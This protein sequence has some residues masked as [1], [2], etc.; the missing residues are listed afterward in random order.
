MH[1][2]QIIG[3]LGFVGVIVG[4]LFAASWI[5]D[6]PSDKGPL[7]R[8]LIFLA[9]IP[10][11]VVSLVP[12]FIGIGMVNHERAV[13]LQA[14]YDVHADAIQSDLSEMPSTYSWYFSQKVS[15][16]LDVIKVKDTFGVQVTC[17]DINTLAREIHSQTVLSH[18]GG[19]DKV[20]LQKVCLTEATPG[21]RKSI[22]GI[23]NADD[24]TAYLALL[25]GLQSASA[26]EG[27]K[28]FCGNVS[29]LAVAADAA[30]RK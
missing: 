16:V 11:A 21:I 5:S 15:D 7:R 28:D 18:D 17:E 19:A 23:A 14:C 6:F 9:G 30:S 29:A 2:S 13:K 22:L 4:T 8:A 1:T 27:A 12:L 10:L 3:S 20:S 24:A 26:N 25:D